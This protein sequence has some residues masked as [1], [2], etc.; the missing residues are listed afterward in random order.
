MPKRDGPCSVG[1]MTI[2]EG[3]NGAAGETTQTSH[4]L[5]G[6]EV[7]GCGHGR[8]VLGDGT[9]SSRTSG[10]GGGGAGSFQR[11][12]CGRAGGLVGPCRAWL[13]RKARQGLEARA[14]DARLT[15]RWMSFRG[16]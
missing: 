6:F 9:P 1:K 16:D 15:R 7:G 12:Q 3:S 5:E 8:T 13:G 14:A 2:Y 11:L 10:T 4:G